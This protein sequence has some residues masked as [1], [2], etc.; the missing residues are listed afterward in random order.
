VDD[1]RLF[2]STNYPTYYQFMQDH[3]ATYDSFIA[4][5]DPVIRSDLLTSTIHEHMED[6]IL[7]ELKLQPKQQQSV[8]SQ[9]PLMMITT[10]SIMNEL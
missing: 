2:Y 9:S 4:E 10:S 8:P 5:A 3:L 6:H 7:E 1:L